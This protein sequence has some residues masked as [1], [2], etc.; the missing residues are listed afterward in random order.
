MLLRSD[1]PNWPTWAAQWVASA[2]V[3]MALGKVMH[4]LKA[5]AQAD[6]FGRTVTSDL[7]SFAFWIL[8]A[9]LASIL[10]PV[11]LAPILRWWLQ[12][13]LEGG[14]QITG[15]DLLLVLVSAILHHVARLLD[16][17]RAMAD[18]YRQIV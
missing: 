13:R 10:I 5:M 12:T 17:A 14:G 1:H 18:D 7:R 16:A 8:M 2:A 3:L 11:A 4:M 15:S 6:P 9:T